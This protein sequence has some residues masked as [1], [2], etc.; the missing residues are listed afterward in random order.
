[1]QFGVPKALRTAQSDRVGSFIISELPVGNYR[2]VISHPG[3]EIKEIPVTVETAEVSALLR[4]SL[5][6]AP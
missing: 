5:E 3:F 6:R 1:M 4:I 2:L